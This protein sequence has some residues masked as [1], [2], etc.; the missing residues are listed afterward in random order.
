MERSFQKGREGED[1]LSALIRLQIE[2]R[3]K[4]NP[5]ALTPLGSHGGVDR[6]NDRM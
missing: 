6:R 4:V 3:K 1:I 5:E 2:R